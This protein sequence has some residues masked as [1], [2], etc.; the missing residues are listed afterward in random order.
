M[1]RRWRVDL[2]QPETRLDAGVTDRCKF[3]WCGGISAA[4]CNRALQYE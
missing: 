4:H 3:F 2:D 1:C